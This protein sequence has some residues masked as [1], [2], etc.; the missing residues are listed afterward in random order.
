MAQ[1]QS[2]FGP[3]I[4]DVQQQQ[5]QQDQELAMRQAQLGAGQ[6]LMYQAASAGQRAGRS[7]AGLF[8]VED[9]KLKEA[10]AR[11]ELKNAISA[12]WDGQDP[13]EAYK[14]MAKEAARL[15][16][17]QEA[18][19]AA[20]QVKAAEESA[21]DK[22][23]KRIRQTYEIGKLAAQ[24][25]EAL[26][27]AQQATAAKLPSLVQYQEA[28]DALDDALQTE[29]DP[30]VRTRLETRKKELDS[31]INKESTREPKDK[32]P[33]SVGQDREAISQERY[34][35]GFYELTPAEKAVVNKKA[36]ERAERLKP[37]Q[38][39]TVEGEKSFA[40]QMGE[41]DAKAVVEARKLSKTAV[42]ELES[43]NEMA[44]R[45][46]QNITSGTFA[47]GRV[48]VAN[49]FNTIGLLGAND[50]KKLANSEAYT[51]SAGDLVLAKIKSLGSNPSN[52]DREFIVRIVPQ[53]ENSPQARA[54]L[55]SYLQKRAN[56]VIKESSSLESYAR[57]NKG[58]SGYVPTVPLTI[59]PQTTKKASDMTDQELIDAYKS[60]RR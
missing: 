46:Q 60:G 32:T 47:S 36:D 34:D 41:E 44:R 3:S 56:D 7:I 22:E 4:Y 12:Q 8:G 54:E 29:Q 10:S 19:S 53:L 39:V 15:G 2:L 31:Y 45:N 58:L 59:S 23:Q 37:S 14:I 5:M 35:K 57:Q 40:K 28:R 38:N 49:F 25:Q 26:R 30:Q 51:K 18:I 50:V 13:V 1:Q 33:P 55:I 24:T 27:K 48:G 11:Q 16:L 17:T 6:G 21:L 52:A 9:P 43:L 20:A 42:G